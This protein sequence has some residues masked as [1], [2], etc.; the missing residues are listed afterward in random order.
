MHWSTARQAWRGLTFDADVTSFGL[1]AFGWL[2][3]NPAEFDQPATSHIPPTAQPSPPSLQ[4][5]SEFSIPACPLRIL[6]P[7]A[8]GPL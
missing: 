3:G 7:P 5:Y 4:L 1:G 6:R 2:A 8:A